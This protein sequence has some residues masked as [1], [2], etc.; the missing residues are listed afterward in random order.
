MPIPRRTVPI[1]LNPAT[2]TQLTV[3]ALKKQLTQ[4]GLTCPDS[5]KDKLEQYIQEVKAAL[6]DGHT[7]TYAILGPAL[8]GSETVG[9]SFA[10]LAD[11]VSSANKTSRLATLDD[12]AT[13]NWEPDATGDGYAT[14]LEYIQFEDHFTW[15]KDNRPSFTGVVD[16]PPT[17]TGRYATVDAV[18]DLFVQV[19]TTASATLVT[20]LDH[21]S[22]ESALSNAIAPLNEA[23]V[24][25]YDVT[26]SRVIFLVENYNPVTQE[27]DGIGVL[28][29]QWRLTIKD[30][31]E[32]KQNPQHDT[33][34]TIKS[35]SVL[36]SSLDDMYA[37]YDAAAAHFGGPPRKAQAVRAASAVVTP[38]PVAATAP[39]AIAPDQFTAIP[40]GPS[41]LKIFD[42]LPPADADTFRQSLPTLSN[43][44]VLQAIVLYAPNL[45]N[46]GSIDNT[47]SAATTTYSQSVTSGFTFST[48]QTFSAQLAV[49]A[50]IE[51]VK[52]SLTVGFSLSFTEEWSK[53][54]TTTI[55]FSVPPGKL[56]FTYQGYLLTALLQFDASSGKYSYLSTARFLTDVL[57]TSEAPLTGGAT[58]RSL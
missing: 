55:E 6:P 29:I 4:I 58:F 28:T 26:D 30:Y 42:A 47:T 37:D 11:R 44:D 15:L 24:S 50:S 27:A 51:V 54:K 1:V 39:A 7:Q 34:L 20:G 56:A 40:P 49:E 53:S 25:D 41:K 21:A 46:V 35:R 32:K 17:S 2:P 23:G 57:A 36:Y 16:N 52:A 33:T 48:T 5:A 31:K 10:E 19:G 45:Q 43:T 18:K 3:D 14:T 13:G 38:R 8:P 9:L 12:A 22:I